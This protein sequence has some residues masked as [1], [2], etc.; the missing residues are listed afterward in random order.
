M[1]DFRK[2][3]T[4]LALGS[5]SCSSEAIWSCALGQDTA[6]LWLVACVQRVERVSVQ[7]GQ[8]G[9]D[10]SC[11]GLCRSPG[12]MR[13]PAN[14]AFQRAGWQQGRYTEQRD[15]SRQEQIEGE[16]WSRS[17][18]E[19]MAPPCAGLGQSPTTITQ[20]LVYKAKD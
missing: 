15:D 12:G 16:V 11:P 14:G 7:R 5:A 1:A 4:F 20:G 9:V 6:Y 8:A 18:F 13:V 10:N 2:E 17:S 3:L 19:H